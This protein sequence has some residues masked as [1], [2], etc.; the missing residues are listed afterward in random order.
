MLSYL[1]AATQTL[2]SDSCCGSICYAY[3]ATDSVRLRVERIIYK[4]S[5]VKLQAFD[6]KRLSLKSNFAHLQVHPAPGA[7]F[8]PVRKKGYHE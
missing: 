1:V 5:R 4:H 2:S 3:H 8:G 6:A 7:S